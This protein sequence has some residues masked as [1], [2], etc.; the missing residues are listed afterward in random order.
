M[1]RSQTLLATSLAAAL[2]FVA[3]SAFAQ[4]RGG[5]GHG[6]AS[7]SRGGG[8]RGAGV[9][10]GG[11]GVSRG[12]SRSISPRSFSGSPNVYSGRTYGPR[13]YSSVRGGYG[14]YYVRGG[15]FSSFAPVHFYRPY[16]VFRPRLSI[17]FGIWAGYPFAYRYAYYDPFY[18]P[19]VYGYPP[20]GY[21]AYD[22]NVTPG[23]APYPPVSGYAP[24]TSYSEPPQ[25]TYQGSA[26]GSAGVA[27]NQSNMGGLSFEISP[28]DAELVVDGRSIGTV[29]EFTANTQPL[30]LPAGRHQIEVRASGYR[31]MS[32]DVDI[33]AGQVIPY[34]GTL[35]R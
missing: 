33:V 15:R 25:G 24:P 22:Y 29:G 17:G 13:G 2:V 30:G 10:R 34:Q 35:E 5:G 1:T 23:Y 8:S 28:S 32:F 6:G 16:Y 20:Y 11:G 26:Q 31:T 18:D 21:P 14:G 27:P 19:Y 3:P 7:A 9:Y 4:H 12:P